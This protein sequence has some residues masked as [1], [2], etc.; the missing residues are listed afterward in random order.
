MSRTKAS[1]LTWLVLIQLMKSNYL[2]YF[3]LAIA[4]K[5]NKQSRHV[6]LFRGKRL[7]MR[8]Y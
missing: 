7:V 6:A 1:S 4:K 2:D 8:L 3:D 5:E